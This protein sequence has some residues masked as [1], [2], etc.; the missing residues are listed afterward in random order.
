MSVIEAS[1]EAAFFFFFF[2]FGLVGKYC[3]F[4]EKMYKSPFAPFLTTRPLHRKQNFFLVWPE[5]GLLRD[6]VDLS[7]QE[8]DGLYCL[9]E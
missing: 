9:F 8:A 2:W 7:L 5:L 1:R 3:A 6:F 4:W